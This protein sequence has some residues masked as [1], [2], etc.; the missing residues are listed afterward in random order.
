MSNWYPLDNAAQIFPALIKKRQTNSFR[1]SALLYEDIDKDILK[2]AVVKT[3]ERYPT[4]KVNLRKGLFW[5]YLNENSFEPVV[6]KEDPY[7][8]ESQN[9]RKQNYYLFNVMYYGRRI[10]IEV[11]HALTDGNGGIE[12]LKS[13]VYNYLLLK[14]CNIPD[15]GKILT[16]DFEQLLDEDQDSFAYNYQKDVKQKSQ[17][18]K[19]FK[20]TGKMH[21]ADWTTAIQAIMSLDS[22]KLAAKKYN[23][24]I[25]E[26][27]GA[28]LIYSIHLEY[29]LKEKNKK[30]KNRPI[31]LFVPVNVRKY[32]KSKTLRN[33]VLFIRT[34]S[35]LKDDV[36][37]QDVVNHVKETF[38]EEISKD[39]MLA[40]LKTNMKLEK[41][42]FVRFVP[43][44]LKVLIIRAV[45]KFIGTGSNT[46]S[47]SNLGVVET[48]SEMIQYVERFD[49]SNG[50]T[51]ES[52]VNASIVTYNNQVVLTFSSRIIERILQKRVIKLL[53]EDGV[54]LYVETNDLEV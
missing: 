15:E 49:F 33:F 6:K 52:P 14:G 8:C 20:V 34:T 37:L 21:K 12:F 1:L 18:S 26:Y 44:F 42:V 27:I 17:E 47:L 35:N 53:I 10:S 5:F 32:F 54:S 23:A 13:L 40:R 9:F 24:T 7:F 30:N 22:L 45:Y 2:N 41:N 38:K 28:L 4:F 51:I 31:R 48:P 50:A 29:K 19:A 39:Q 11:F 25:T 43:L 3:L 36:T 16:N 46:I